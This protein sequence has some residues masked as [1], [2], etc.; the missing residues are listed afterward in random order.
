MQQL[1][2]AKNHLVLKCIFSASKKH[3]FF[4]QCKRR[5]AVTNSVPGEGEKAMKPTL[6]HVPRNRHK[7]TR[8]RFLI[9]LLLCFLAWLYVHKLQ[10]DI[11]L[12]L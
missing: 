3:W 12:S 1:E 11:S 7:T 10:H 5:H 8:M 6:P 4:V 2:R 9:M